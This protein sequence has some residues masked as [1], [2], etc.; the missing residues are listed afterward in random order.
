M[1]LP[2]GFRVEVVVEQVL[3]EVLVARQPI[4]DRQLEV[5]GYELLYRDER[6]LAPVGEGAGVRATAT[7][8]VDGLL[9]LGREICTDGDDAFVNVPGSMLRAG[10]LLDLPRAGLVLELLESIDDTPENRTAIQRHLDAGFRLALDDVVPDDPRIGLIDLVHL[11]KVDV[12]AVGLPAAVAFIRALTDRGVAVVAEKV[13]TPEIFDA[14][15]AA[16]AQLIQGF[17]FT[18]PRAVRA[19]RPLGLAANHLQLLQLLAKEDIDLDAVEDLIRSDLTL[20]D[21][22]LRLVSVAGGWHE[23]RSIHHGL[24]MLGHRR[25]QRWI[26]LLVMSAIT[27]NAPAELLTT[28]SVRARYCEELQALRTDTGGLDAFALGMFSVLGSSGVVPDE[29]LAELPLGEE[30][31]F[32]LSGGP[33]VYRDLIGMCLAA[34]QADW[35]ALVTTARGLGIDP[36]SLARA[37]VEALRWATQMSAA[38]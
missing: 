34:E 37:H 33:G 11:V 15:A 4:V 9:A 25:V 5:V 14:V 10:M 12:L 3:G 31:R 29:V 21:R 17:F 38:A 2:T 20:S 32:A 35:D 19:V 26:N 16:G 24:L 1:A 6:G 18:Q 28:A 30:I 22:F 23:I 8:L 36:R 27:S 7:V 13:E